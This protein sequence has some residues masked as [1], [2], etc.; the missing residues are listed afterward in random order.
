MNEFDPAQGQEPGGGNGDAARCQELGEQLIAAPLGLVISSADPAACEVAWQDMLSCLRARLAAEPQVMRL[1]G[2]E[3]ALAGI[4]ERLASLDF[5][6]ATDT[7]RQK[8]LLWMVMKAGSTTEAIEW[9]TL[10]RSIAALPGARLRLVLLCHPLIARSLSPLPTRQ[11]LAW[12]LDDEPVGDGT[13][14]PDQ[15]SS[16]RGLSD[17]TPG[18][19]AMHFPPLEKMPGTPVTG[20]APAAAVIRKRSRG[21]SPAPAAATSPVLLSKQPPPGAHTRDT[22]PTATS[23]RRHPALIVN[24]LLLAGAL[25]ATAL[26]TALLYPRHVIAILDQI[27]ARPPKRDAGPATESPLLLKR[28]SG[29]STLAPTQ[30]V[31]GDASPAPPRPGPETTTTAPGVDTAPAVAPPTPAVPDAPPKAEDQG[32]SGKTLPVNA[33]VTAAASE[34]AKAKAVP[35]AAG[36]DN[37]GRQD[38]GKAKPTPTKEAG[39]TSS[40]VGIRQAAASSFYVQHAALE[41]REVAEK[42]R[43]GFPALAKSRVVRLAANAERGVLFAVVSG[44]FPSRAAATR[45]AGL[46]GVPS[47]PWVRTQRSLADALAIEPQKESVR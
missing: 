34:P 32:P 24:A 8:P 25:L 13:A 36:S 17:P 20:A 47:G 22:Q 4:N 6:G 42:W 41:S 46:P 39:S 40:D 5:Q 37:A 15:S 23:H 10:V 30:T 45:F 38:E 26:V 19:P 16:Q 33:A 27:Y 11:V 44:P 14:S 28:E 31:P 9:R 7:E 35:S 3:Q 1:P 43:A 29:I 18:S 21:T 2:I 12:D